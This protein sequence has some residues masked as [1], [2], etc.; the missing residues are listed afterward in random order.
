MVPLLCAWRRGAGPGVLFA[1]RRA[2]GL[3]KGLPP[4]LRAAP[5]R[6]VGLGTYTLSGLPQGDK[7]VLK[8]NKL[9][10]VHTQLPYEYYS[11]P[12]CR[13]DKIES[14][15]ENLGEVLRG[16]RIETSPYE[17]MSAFPELQR[18]HRL[19]PS[20]FRPPDACLLQIA[21]RIDEQCKVLCRIQSLTAAQAKAFTK[22]IED[23]S[24][25]RL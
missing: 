11:L 17:V 6:L 24:R 3:C 21:I 23:E 25:V 2:A 15:A 20:V 10:S 4:A 9:T 1:R 14:S 19:C 13:P 18:A 5:R 22:K 16:D 8:V 12:Y 7:Q